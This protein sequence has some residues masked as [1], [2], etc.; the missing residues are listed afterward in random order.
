[1]LTNP[2]ARG[3]ALCANFQH[4]QV[5][6][7]VTSTVSDIPGALQ[8][9]GDC[10]Y[11]LVNGGDGTIGEVVTQYMAEGKELPNFI[12]V[13]G[14]TNNSVAKDVGAR[15]GK[16][17]LEQIAN[18]GFGRTAWRNTI[19]IECAGRVRYGFVFAT[20]LIVRFTDE[21]Y[22]GKGFGGLKVARVVAE[23]LAK[24][25]IPLTRYRAFWKFEQ[26]RIKIDDVS[27]A[28]PR[29]AQLSFISTLDQQILF[30]RPFKTA[31]SELKGF[32]VL[33]NALPSRTI[34]RHF[35]GLVRG[36]FEGAGHTACEAEHFEI[37]GSERYFVDGE[38]L[39]C[40]PGESIRIS[41]GP[42][43]RFVV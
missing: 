37:S 3:H 40:P 18:G 26:N 24:V 5:N 34:A 4:P 32:N 29:G 27:L 41:N 13:L 9:L 39:V 19:R 10:R 33:V 35:F 30:F 15:P 11:L 12:P 25:A 23:Q 20:G 43:V 2:H 36:T 1:M 42:R 16:K 38:L 31:A 14:G 8:A 22:R 6:E 7:R 17:A 21:Y 28:L